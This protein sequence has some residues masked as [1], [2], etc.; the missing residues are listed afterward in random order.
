[1]RV[2]IIGGGVAGL[3]AAWLLN[4]EHEVTLFESRDYLGGHAHTLQVQ[5]DTGTLAV[6]TGFQ[7]VCRPLYPLFLRLLDLLHVRLSESRISS[8]FLWSRSNELLTL[9]PRLSTL[10]RPLSSVQ[11]LLQMGL[12]IRSAV[13]V[14]ERG[15]WALTVEEFGAR[16]RLSRAFLE[17]FFYPFLSSLTFMSVDDTRRTSLRAAMMYVVFGR[18]ANPLDKVRMLEFAN[19]CAEYVDALA[20][21]LGRTAVRLNSGVRA[22]HRSGEQ[23]VVQ[24]RSGARSD[25]DQIIVAAP[26]FT[27]AALVED[28]PGTDR[29]LAVLREFEYSPTTVVVHSDRRHLPA[30]RAAWS[31]HNVSY[32]GLRCTSTLWVG[33]RAGVDVFKTYVE[34]QAAMP[35]QVHAN[36]TYHHPVT[37]PEHF[38]LQSRLAALQGQGGLWFAGGYTQGIDSHESGVGSA[39]A[40]ARRLLGRRRST[41]LDR[42]LS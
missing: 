8:T 4:E 7:H 28:L 21:K 18:R 15:D 9:P 14:E 35:A 16:S 25:F 33:S 39:V 3:V 10:R 26:A 32:D 19:G 24:E 34:D 23:L 20:T 29:L 6:D 17:G 5:H 31:E 30:A 41:N 36:Y 1:M 2:A 40:V 13:R 37:T 38:R 12:A 27:A 22:L 42:L 11:T